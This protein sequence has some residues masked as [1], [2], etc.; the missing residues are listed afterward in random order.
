MPYQRPLW[1]GRYPKLVHILDED[2]MAPKGNVIARNICVGGRWGDFEAKAKPLVAFQDNMMDKDPRF[3]DAEHGNFQLKA[4]SPAYKLGFQRI[5]MEKIGL[6]DAPGRTFAACLSDGSAGDGT[7]CP[8]ILSTGERT[9][10][11]VILSS[12]AACWRAA[13][14]RRLCFASSPGGGGGESRLEDRMDAGRGGLFAAVRCNGI[15]LVRAVRP[16][17]WTDSAASSA[18]SPS[19]RVV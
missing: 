18:K 9:R 2:P 11:G 19:G 15:P 8:L 12:A 4:D 1:A 10:N 16:A 13:S 7:C 5:P 17:C 14:G 6:S 3:V